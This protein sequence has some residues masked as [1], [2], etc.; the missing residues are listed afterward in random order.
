MIERAAELTRATR[1]TKVSVA[2]VIDG[3]GNS[4]VS[5]GVGFYD[6]LLATL[7]HHGLF[8]LT[9]ETSGD[10]EVDDHHT[11][12]DTALLL[13]EAFDMCLGRR[14]GI[15]RFGAAT[16]PMD[17]AVGRCAV[18][19]GGRPYFVSDLAFVGER[20]GAL[21]TQMIT[22][23]LESLA[24]TARFTLHVEATGR[25]DHHIAEAT[26]KSVGRALRLAL[27]PDPRRSG[28]PSTKGV[29]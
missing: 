9:I 10:L 1:E 12:E 8:D 27:E 2:L 20:I 24:R 7:A 22:H 6:H 28:V 13:G 19:A 23:C 16:V 3:T 11:V 15:T 29:L 25:N 14:D 4:A 18:D 26:F 17:E 21:S 5:T